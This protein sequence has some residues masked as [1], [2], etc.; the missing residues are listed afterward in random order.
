M[1]F[2][3]EAESR[4]L[5]VAF[6]DVVMHWPGVSSARMFGH[7]GYRAQGKLF[8]FLVNRAVVILKLSEED[9]RHLRQERDGVPFVGSRGNV[10]EGWTQ[11]PI[12]DVGELSGLSPYLRRSYER[13]LID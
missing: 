4:D 1:T 3:T 11:V 5:R 12:G 6:E 13:A 10:I 7:P 9:R 8:A 2:Y